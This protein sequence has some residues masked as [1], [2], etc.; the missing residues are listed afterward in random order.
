MKN[1]I[2]YVYKWTHLP[3]G[4]WYIGSKSAKG[5]NP[6][7]HEK[8]ICSKPEV[9]QMILN[10]RDNWYFEIIETGDPSDMRKLE[11]KILKKLDAKNSN[12]S[13]N[14]SNADGNPANRLG[15]KESLAT[16]QKKSKARQGSK[17]PSYG[18]RG[19]LSPLWG[20]E[21]SNETKERI[22][23]GLKKY[24][25]NRPA[26]HSKNISIALKGNPKLAR[27]GSD[28]PM[29]GKTPSDYN[30][31]MTRLKNAGE[32]NPMKKPEHQRTCEYCHKTVAKN[33]YTLY[34]GI[35]CK[36]SLNC[37]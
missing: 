2:A 34:H 18:K 35:K 31:A 22:S 12:M 26:E 30:K 24:N 7:N 13:F 25:E 14:E 15:R 16:R 28:N 1:T 4:K 37:E 9:K 19:K 6:N 23:D 17:N 8:Y 27:F 20:R 5:C 11:T 29:F 3:S 10:D 21:A 32:N 33:H 36:F